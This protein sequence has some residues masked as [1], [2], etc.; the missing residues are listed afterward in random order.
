[1]E[2]SEN[3]I[4]GFAG[5]LESQGK[6]PATVESYC[7]DAGRFLEYIG[8]HKLQAKD[9]E[10]DTLVHYQ[11]FMRNACSESDNTIRRSVIGVRQ[12]YRY[13]TEFSILST[14]GGAS[15][16]DYVVIPVRDESMPEPLS[17]ADIDEI[18][19]VV[20]ASR[21]AIKRFRDGAIVCMLAYE[22]LKANEMISLKW[23]DLIV[24]PDRMSL[25]VS[26]PRS[27]AIALSQASCTWL[28]QYRKAYEDF[29]SDPHEF[30]TRNIFLAFKGREAACTIPALT[31]HGLKF[32]L[33]ELGEKAGIPKLNSEALRHFTI[34]HLIQAGDSTEDI[35]QKL[36]LRRPG[37][38]AKHFHRIGKG[39][40]PTT[41]T[42][43]R[44]VIA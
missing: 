11:S 36:G 10:P 23:R 12:F 28:K 43:E 29:L 13:L 17:D 8:S 18:M 35:M 6:Q 30:A 44:D 39:S 32:M 19:T 16:F 24:L 20:Q 21:P 5:H 31:R 1:M 25:Q 27:R 4:K 40:A 9:V 41:A 15:P 3:I 42:P 34:T 22:G 7:R 37:I 33:Y 38:I 2:R 14:S 26:G